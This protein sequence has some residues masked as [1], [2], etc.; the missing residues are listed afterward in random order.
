[1]SKF[2]LIGVMIMVAMAFV[3]CENTTAP[4][5][6]EME[7]S[8][9]SLGKGKG[10]SSAAGETAY[11]C[12]AD[13]EFVG[14]NET[15]NPDYGVYEYTLWA[16]QHN[17]AGTVTITNDDDNIY[18]T[19]NTN[20]TAD[21]AEVHVYV[22]TQAEKDAGMIPTKRPAPGHAD[23]VIESI[24][25]DAVTVTIPADLSCGENFYISTH[26]ALIANSTE[27][28]E[29]GSGDNAGET[30]YAGNDDSPA[31]FADTKGA[32]WGFV[33]Y[34]VECFFDISGTVY[35][36]ADNSGDMED[37][38]GFGGITVTLLDADGNVVATTTTNADGSYLFEHVPGGAD[39]TVVS[40]SP[41]GDYLAN[42]NAGG[43]SISNLSSDVTDVDFGFVP[44][45]DLS[46]S[47][48]FDGDMDCFGYSTITINGVE[49]SSLE[50]QLPGFEYTVVVTAYD[51]EGNVLASETV[52]GSLS[53][54][55]EL[56]L[57]LSGWVCPV[58]EYDPCDTNMDGVVDAA[59]AAACNPEP[60]T[61]DDDFPTWGQDISH[62][63]LAF[64]NA[65]GDFYLIKIDEYPDAGDD[66]LDND[67][68]SYLTQLAAMGAIPAGYELI[69][70][71]IK[72]GRQVTSFY[73]YGS[74]NTNGDG[75]DTAP[76]GFP[77]TYNGT[78]DNEGN[79]N[80][81]DATYDWI[82]FQ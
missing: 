27:G 7:A 60:P 2:K 48:A 52:S 76:A 66:D 78:S 43:Y 13:G 77:L 30:A 70:S 15:N 16:G 4:L 46:V 28:D 47:A 24:N 37:E 19:Y 51:L 61:G 45:Y 35:E 9:G 3:A 56:S 64:Q 10:G 79:Q 18:V 22:W 17:D 31:C 82:L 14:F 12:N 72:G 80:L 67:I 38:A 68:E 74:Y 59:E 33:N 57:T 49:V 8:E 6:P 42:E 53:E 21:L 11:A 81:I 55:T 63:V 40:G 32:W 54:D 62:V 50:N 71:S 36:D 75:A 23:Y 65:S 1:M 26:A 34:T 20:S 73:N 41:E 25:A 29:A 44:L 39:Y 58:I 5:A 69:G